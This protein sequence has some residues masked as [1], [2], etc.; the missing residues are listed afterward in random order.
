MVWFTSCEHGFERCFRPCD[1]TCIIMLLAKPYE[2]TH[3]VLSILLYLWNL[4]E[5]V[6]Q[7]QRPSTPPSCFFPRLEKNNINFLFVNQWLCSRRE[8][9][10]ISH[11]IV[12]IKWS[13]STPMSFLWYE[14]KCYFDLMFIDTIDI[15]LFPSCKWNGEEKEYA[16]YQIYLQVPESKWIVDMKHAIFALLEY[17]KWLKTNTQD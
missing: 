5:P 16:N 17:A 4:L 9:K 14:W 2:L 10:H 12:L 15:P 7:S 3:S 8:D 13:Q 6:N 11:P 1:L